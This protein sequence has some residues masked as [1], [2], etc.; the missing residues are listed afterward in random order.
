MLILACAPLG[1]PGD[2]T[3][4]LREVITSAKFI[5]A[6]DSR[7]LTRLAHDLGIVY[8]GKVIS[9]F[10]GNESERLDQLTEILE[11]GEDLLVITDAGAP[12]VSDPGYRL[13][14]AAIEKNI[15]IKV[16]PGPSAPVTALLLS[17]APT[18]RFCFE[19]FTPRTSGTRKAWFEDLAEEERTIIFFEAPHRLKE[20]LVDACEV[21][22][23]NRLGAICREMTKTYE[24]TIRG[25]LGELLA[26]S[27][28][29]EI[30]GEITI[31]LHG[32]DAS[33]KSYS[34]DELVNL[35]LERESAGMS[36]KDA[37]GIVAK[38]LDLPKRQ[39]FDAL[40]SHKSA[41]KI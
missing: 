28:D 39:V 14:R 16:L 22:G 35:V 29:R 34:G 11:S 2:A 21:F 7:K 41:D 17:G 25:T 9:Y 5:A 20:S 15:E 19:G 37:I 36:R 6:E 26:W 27:T 10:E 30:L 32:F 12:G 8:T 38:Q 1:N 40:V 31:V 3:T 33:T 24:E 4:R 13:I 18:D 23:V